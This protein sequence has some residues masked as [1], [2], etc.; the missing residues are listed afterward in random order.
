MANK[1]IKLDSVVDSQDMDYLLSVELNEP[2]FLKL[3]ENLIGESKFLQ[4]SPAQGLIHQENRASHH[5][6]EILKPF[7]G[8]L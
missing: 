7:T 2:R 5:V 3:L 8:I 6:L 1:K 4:N